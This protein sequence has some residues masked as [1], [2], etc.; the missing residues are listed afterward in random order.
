MRLPAGEW[1]LIS[2]FPAGALGEPDFA[3]AVHAGE[4]LGKEGILSDL[5][6]VAEAQEEF[7]VRALVGP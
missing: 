2:L 5:H 3:A 4:M 6:V 7:G 1:K